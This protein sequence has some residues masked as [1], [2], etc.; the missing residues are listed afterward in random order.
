MR[1]LITGIVLAG[2]RGSRLGG[3]DKGL[4]EYQGRPL[5]AHVTAALRPQVSRII[6][7]AN[8]HLDDYA[9]YGDQVLPDNLADYAGPLAGIHTGLTAT[10][11]PYALIVACDMP[12][13]PSNVSELML[14]ALTKRNANLC[15]TRD[16][17][18]LQPFPMLIEVS[19]CEKTLERAANEHQAV[20]KW[21]D[22]QIVE[23][24]SLDENAKVLNI[25]TRGDLQDC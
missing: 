18:G 16:A 20:M 5:V 19:M 24:I 12:Q 14:T 8:R 22:A 3:A 15:I 6:I 21:L 23:V 17:N 2:G 4:V 7:I 25:N 10:I 1:D 11:T 9:P 13:L